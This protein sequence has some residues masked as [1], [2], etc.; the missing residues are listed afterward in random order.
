M[1]WYC[2]KGTILFLELRIQ[3]RARQNEIAG[4]MGDRLRVRVKSP[5]VDG[6]ANQCL[7]E[8]LGAQ[9]GVSASK[10]ELI[11]GGHRRD[12]RI[13]IHAPA[14]QPDWFLVLMKKESG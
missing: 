13:A 10:V 1:A 12:K 3:P 14:R 7:A 8:F 9:F 5:P 11:S 4:I 2:W 6:K